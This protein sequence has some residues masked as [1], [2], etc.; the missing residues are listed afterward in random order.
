MR[1]LFYSKVPY[2]KSSRWVRGGNLLRIGLYFKTLS[3]RSTCAIKGMKLLKY[4]IPSN[5]HQ[6][7]STFELDVWN[8]FWRWSWYVILTV[9]VILTRLIDLIHIRRINWPIFSS[10]ISFLKIWCFSYILIFIDIVEYKKWHRKANKFLH[11]NINK[12]RIYPNYKKK[13]LYV[14]AILFQRSLQIFYFFWFSCINTSV[15]FTKV[16][17]RKYNIG[18]EGRIYDPG[19]IVWDS[20]V[21]DLRKF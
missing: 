6:L 14:F 15:S 7:Y 13:F 8:L 1:F 20:S 10:Y 19:T 5:K 2:R 12:A 16:G 4:K 17:I 11:N 21:L 3:C 18:S 9:T